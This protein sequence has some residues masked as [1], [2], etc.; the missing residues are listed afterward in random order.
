MVMGTSTMA[1][2][3]NPKTTGITPVAITKIIQTETE[4]LT[5][6]NSSQSK[7]K[8][9]LFLL[10]WAFGLFFGVFGFLLLI[11]KWFCHQATGYLI[12]VA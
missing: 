3:T 7:T 10:L 2:K 12:G 11:D 1:I 8:E 5:M 9:G 4:R 6:I